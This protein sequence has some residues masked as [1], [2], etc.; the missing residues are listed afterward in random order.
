MGVLVTPMALAHPIHPIKS[1]S[2]NKRR[3]LWVGWCVSSW[4]PWFW[5]VY[6]IYYIHT[7][8]H[9]CILSNWIK[10]FLRGIHTQ[11]W[12]G[13]AGVLDDL[14]LSGFKCTFSCIIQYSLYHNMDIYPYYDIENTG[15]YNWKYIWNQTVSNRHM[16]PIGT[17]WHCTLVSL[18]PSQS[19][20][21]V[22]VC[23]LFI[24]IVLTVIGIFMTIDYF[25]NYTLRFL[26]LSSF[27]S[28]NAQLSGYFRPWT[29]SL[30][31]GLSMFPLD[32][33]MSCLQSLLGYYTGEFQALQLII[34]A[35]FGA[36]N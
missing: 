20:G 7:T 29:F 31:I 6:S 9:S 8:H 27:G 35:A 4:Q 11:S 17:I 33:F 15:L 30:N 12:C 28:A 3:N 36:V 24:V 10:L 34:L 5:P 25:L 13:Y 1:R 18:T 23:A 19:I 16:V 14:I 32:S 26:Y 2:R 21:L 22:F